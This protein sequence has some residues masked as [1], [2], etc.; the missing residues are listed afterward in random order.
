MVGLR[1]IS[2]YVFKNKIMIDSKKK[3]KK[4]WNT[5]EPYNWAYG[6]GK[7]NMQFGTSPLRSNQV[8]PGHLINEDPEPFC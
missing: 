3:K 7:A 5:E 4:H 6:P 8:R 1:S 2:K